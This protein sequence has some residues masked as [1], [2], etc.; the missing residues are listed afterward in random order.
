MTE[1]KYKTLAMVQAIGFASAVAYGIGYAN[2]CKRV[3][4]TANEWQDMYDR[5]I[6]RQWEM[7]QRRDTLYVKSIRLKLKYSDGSELTPVDLEEGGEEWK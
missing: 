1:K 7:I 2:G 5:H 3:L 4:K 6:N